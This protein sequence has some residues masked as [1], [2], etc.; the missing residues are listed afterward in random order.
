MVYSAGEKADSMYFVE[1]G[2]VVLKEV[3]SAKSFTVSRGSCFGESV[4][5]AVRACSTHCSSRPC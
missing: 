3:D 2:E 5:L 4:L 1:D